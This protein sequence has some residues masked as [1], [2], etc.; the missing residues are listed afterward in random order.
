MT[1]YT[2]QL[3]IANAE[4][5]KELERV[6]NEAN[7]SERVNDYAEQDDVMLIYIQKI[8]FVLYAIIYI[9]MVYMLYVN[10]E[11]SKV[12]FGIMVVL[13]ALVPF[14]FWLVGKYFSDV[15]L[16]IVKIFIKGNANYLY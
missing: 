13:F 16:K 5:D 3:E 1:D 11:T 2:K 10:P 15:L 7:K 14:V 6:T 9:I 12:Y 8:L 4:L